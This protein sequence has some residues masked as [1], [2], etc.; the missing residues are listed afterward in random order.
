M[1]GGDYFGDLGETIHSSVKHPASLRAA[2][3]ALLSAWGIGAGLSGLTPSVRARAHPAL[4]VALGRSLVGPC[5]GL[6]LQE[7][8]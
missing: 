2:L 1:D 7:D 4:T 6:R 8:L 3:D 5:R